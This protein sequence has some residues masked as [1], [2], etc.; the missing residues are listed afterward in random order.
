MDLG[1]QYSEERESSQNKLKEGRVK[2][3]SAGY[4]VRAES[5]NIVVP[6]NG[7]WGLLSVWDQQ[8]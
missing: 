4:S 5:C 2:S 3:N 8:V 7:P 1:I 6:C